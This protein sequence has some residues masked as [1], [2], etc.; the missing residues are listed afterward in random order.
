LTDL[1]VVVTGAGPLGLAAA[2]HLLDRG[3]E[4]LVLEA[5]PA[6]GDNIAQ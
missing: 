2:V 6:V 3:L 1:P 5:G 4:P